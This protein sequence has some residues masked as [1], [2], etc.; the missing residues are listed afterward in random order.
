M[1]VVVDVMVVTELQRLCRF[2][3]VVLMD[4]I[5]FGLSV[6]RNFGET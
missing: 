6:V 5:S 2:T 4:V 1:E 3:P